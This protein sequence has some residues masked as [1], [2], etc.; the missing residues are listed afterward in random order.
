M[1]V[2]VRARTRT[3][4][5]PTHPC[6][7]TTPP[8]V[9]WPGLSRPRDPALDRPSAVALLVTWPVHHVTNRHMAPAGHRARYP[10]HQS[11]HPRCRSHRLEKHIPCLALSAAG[12]HRI[13]IR[14]A[15]AILSLSLSPPLSLS[16]SLHLPFSLSLSLSPSFSPSVSIH[17]PLPLSNRHPPAP[18]EAPKV[19]AA[20][21]EHT[22][23]LDAPAEERN[24]QRHA[25][26][27]AARCH[28]S[29]SLT[30]LLSLSLRQ[31]HP[32]PTPQAR[33]AVT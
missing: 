4:P 31:Y 16:I 18:L 28:S 33:S 26:A 19:P 21:G 3:A 30:H 11:T 25:H 1:R 2:R 29:I 17:P 6:H 14:R 13:R 10:S 24:G 22:A 5:I 27:S 7:V 8:S 9:T 12:P 20:H 15:R 32:C 23:E